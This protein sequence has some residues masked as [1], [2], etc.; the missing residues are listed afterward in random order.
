MSLF[1][2]F[3]TADVSVN[4][5]GWITAGP[6]GYPGKTQQRLKRGSFKMVQA[7]GLSVRQVGD[8]GFSAERFNAAPGEALTQAARYISDA[9]GKYF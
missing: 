8:V 4:G 9:S 7:F 3:S 6:R 5:C 1:A 2:L